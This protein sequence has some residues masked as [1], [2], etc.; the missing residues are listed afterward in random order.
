MMHNRSL[1]AVTVYKKNLKKYEK[2]KMKKKLAI[3]SIVTFFSFLSDAVFLCC[4][5]QLNTCPE[6]LVL[7]RGTIND[8]I[9]NGNVNLRKC[10]LR[11]ILIVQEIKLNYSSLKNN[12]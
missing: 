7:T 3:K 4:V 8:S 1:R 10:T 2:E 11:F 9:S 12:R 5:S 6:R